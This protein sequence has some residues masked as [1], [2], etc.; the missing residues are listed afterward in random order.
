MNID[1]LTIGEARKLAAMF[2]GHESPPA[3]AHPKSNEPIPVLIWTDKRGVIQ[4][5]TTDPDARPITLTNA[6]MCL[7]W[8]KDVGG[9]FGL[10]DIGPTIG[11]KISA[12][13][14]SAVFEGITGVARM[15]DQ[16]IKAW[17]SAPVQG[18]DNV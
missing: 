4:G 15:S 8:S 16:A 12:I 13:I 11:C 2:G 14:P 7:Y 5:L 18:R 3:S 17:A 1:D 6:R 9:V 10:A